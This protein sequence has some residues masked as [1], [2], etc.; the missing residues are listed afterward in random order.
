MRNTALFYMNYTAPY[1]GN[2][3]A[4]MMTLAKSLE[5]KNIKSHFIFPESA[6]K[7]SWVLTLTDAG[8]T[9][10]FI[11]EGSGAKFRFFREIFK[12]KKILFLH[13]HFTDSMAERLLIKLAMLLDHNKRPIVVHY[14]NHYSYHAN[15]VTQL[16]KK[17]SIPGDYLLGCSAGV[18][19]SLKDENLRNDIAFIE[20][21]IAFDRLDS[22]RS[23]YGQRNFLQFGFDYERKGV[24]I[25]LEAFELLHKKYDD[26]TLSISLSSNRKYVEDKITENL[27]KIPAWIKLLEPV[28]NIS[29]YYDE[30]AAFLSP[31]R[32]EGFCYS[33]VE[34]AWCKCPVI[35]SDISGQNGINIRGIIW[36]KS[37]SPSDLADKID[38]FLR[39]TEE[40]KSRLGSRLRE[41]A[42]KYYDLSRWVGQ[43]IAYYEERK[44]LT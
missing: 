9:V 25:S 36:C 19:E 20:N 32:E 11:P 37:E 5:A 38:E 17:A 23:G 30:A 43:M 27:G 15:A 44:L 35:A 33:A 3:L 21:A 8:I 34:A 14:H 24:D 26:L 31:S 12:D 42:I 16:V 13:L 28:E 18:A 40:E 1:P 29:A 6:G 7:S 39:L 4:S 22:S 10:S 2:F 41:S